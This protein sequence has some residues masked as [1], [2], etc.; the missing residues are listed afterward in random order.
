MSG[1][2]ERGRGCAGGRGRGGA[3]Q[4]ITRDERGNRG[5][6]C[7]RGSSGGRGRA[8]GHSL[9]KISDVKVDF[10]DV[11]SNESALNAIQSY[12]KKFA[13]EIGN[14]SYKIQ[15]RHDYG[16]LGVRTDVGTNYFK[17]Q[18]AGLKLYMYFVE[19]QE[20]KEGKGTKEGKPK[21][22]GPTLK[23][24]DAVDNYLFNLEPFK[25]KRSD[26]YY[27]DF[28]SMYSKVP[29]PVEDVVVYPFAEK[30]VSIKVQY[31]KKLKFDDMIK[32]STMQTYTKT[33]Q[34]VTEYTNAL[35]AVIGSKV[36]ENKSVVSLGSNKFFFFDKSIPIEDFQQGLIITLGTFVSVRCSFNN[37]K[38]NLNPT[39]AIFYKAFKPD[40]QPMNVIDLVK[41]YLSTSQTPTESDFKKVQFFLKGVK[42]QRNY[43]K[44]GSAKA[45]QGLNFK[46]N[47][48]TH[49]F[50]DSK[51]R[52]SVV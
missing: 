16:N 31:V 46:D 23:I 30:S 41:D 7:G 32:Y 19:I 21:S 33:F 14:D 29:L 3:A 38:L 47:A 8:G 49:K 26:I 51:H 37:I 42:I 36:L 2:R 45:V 13:T 6:R 48:N 44:R 43:L 22:K 1:G 15:L 17:Y 10:Q 12:K 20:E 4:R 9:Y 39:P 18:V 40:G 5:R 50:E 25:S 34:E 24:K 52:K 27:R 35:I 28:S 11:A